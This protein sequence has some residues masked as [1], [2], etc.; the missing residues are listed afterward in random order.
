MSA[1]DD[2]F[3]EQE[4][5]RILESASAGGSNLPAYRRGSGLTVSEIESIAREAGLDTSGIAAAAARVAMERSSNLFGGAGIMELRSEVPGVVS[6]GDYGRLADTIGDAAGDPGTRN[7][8]FGSLD[9]ESS[10]GASRIRVTVTPESD[11]TSI[12]VHTDASA[13]K[14][15]CYVAAVPGA[16]ALGGITGA[17]IEPS[18]VL[19]GIGIM[20]GAASIGVATGWTAWRV[21][22]RRVKE[23]S[24]AVFAA[25]SGRASELARP[26][27]ETTEPGEGPPGPDQESR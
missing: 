6:S 1:G 11:S 27:D 3:T 12:R 10:R 26:A 25:V 24:A 19:A 2:R 21:Q 8:A 5:A 13:L 4:M 22:A 23:R 7:A 15:L 9:W 18:A 14:G 20:A 17:I 16:L